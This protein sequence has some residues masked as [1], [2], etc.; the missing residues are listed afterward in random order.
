M[1]PWHRPSYGSEKLVTDLPAWLRG[2]EGALG[3]DCLSMGMGCLSMGMDRPRSSNLVVLNGAEWPKAFESVEIAQ[4]DWPTVWHW[5]M[6][7]KTD[8]RRTLQACI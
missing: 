4:E 8:L 5:L 7:C 3:M 1:Q 6:R 2:E